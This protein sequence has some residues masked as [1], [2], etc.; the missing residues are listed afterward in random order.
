MDFWAKFIKK[1]PTK[2]NLQFGRYSNVINNPKR[3]A[4][5]EYAFKMYEAK[6][7][8]DAYKSLLLYLENALGDNINVDNVSKSRFN[9]QII[10][11]SKMILGVVNEDGIFVEVKIG[12]TT[13]H[14]YDFYINLLE[15]NYYRQYTKYALDS[16]G[17]ICIMFQSDHASAS[18]LK[19]YYALREMAISADKNDDVWVQQYDIS[20]IQTEHKYNSTDFEKREKFR[21]FKTKCAELKAYIHENE[22]FL[23]SFP[24]AHAYLLLDFILTMDYLL[25]P[26]GKL[27]RTFED[28]YRSFNNSFYSNP[29]EKVKEMNKNFLLLEEIDEIIFNK[30]IYPTIYTF[31]TPAFTNHQRVAEVIQSETQNMQWY[32]DNN[33]MEIVLAIGR[34]ITGHLF[35][36]YT[37]PAIDRDLL[38]LLYEVNEDSFFAVFDPKYSLIKKNRLSKKGILTKLDSILKTQQ[39][40]YRNIE[41]RPDKIDFSDKAVFTKSFLLV[42][43][44]MNISKSEKPE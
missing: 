37:L 10:Q 42:V 5:W 29:S 34:Y 39:N 27:M 4:Y 15:E 38:H 1:K 24:G 20:P 28:I 12:K 19:L 31:G 32:L 41:I 21:Y 8:S 6:K 25:K 16:E 44:N 14:N 18:P 30:E 43:A 33:K 7:Y 36:N 23:F 22:D 17:N 11:G 9:F 2:L 35:Y 13:T 26:E 40:T 3:N